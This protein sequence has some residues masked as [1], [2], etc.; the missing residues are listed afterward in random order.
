MYGAHSESKALAYGQCCRQSRSQ[1]CAGHSVS[2]SVTRP[3]AASMSTIRT[4]RRLALHVQSP[5]ATLVATTNR[6]SSAAAS[7]RRRKSTTWVEGRP[8]GGPTGVDPVWA[9]AVKSA[10]WP[11][12]NHWK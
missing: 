4:R 10:G 2:E 9:Q 7:G 5:L 3:S 12:R 8:R 11:A 6:I 1:S